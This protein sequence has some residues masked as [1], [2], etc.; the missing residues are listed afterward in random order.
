MI[1]SPWCWEVMRSHTT[2]LGQWNVNRGCFC[3][4][5]ELGYIQLARPFVLTL[6]VREHGDGASLSPGTWVRLTLFWGL[7]WLSSCLSTCVR[8]QRDRL[9]PSDIQVRVPV[10]LWVSVFYKLNYF[11]FSSVALH[12]QSIGLITSSACFII[13]CLLCLPNFLVASGSFQFL[14]STD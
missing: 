10:T 12:L 8:H 2:C 4:I 13:S 6:A 14:Y 1:A 11:Q 3:H 9:P 7:L 5:F